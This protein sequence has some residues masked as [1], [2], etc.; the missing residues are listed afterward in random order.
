[1]TNYFCQV[2]GIE[3]IDSSDGSA[4]WWM[5]ANK[6]GEIYDGLLARFRTHRRTQHDA[7]FFDHPT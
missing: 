1:M 2:I 3:P 6:A 7:P 4:N 5:S